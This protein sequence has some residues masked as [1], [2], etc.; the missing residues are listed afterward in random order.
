LSIRGAVRRFFLVTALLSAA[1]PARAQAV[2]GPR[3]DPEARI[4]Y[5]GPDPNTVHI[6]LG[7]NVP[8]GS[9]LRVGAIAAGGAS[10]RAGRSG[11]SARA[12][13]IARFTFD[14]FR[15]RRWGVSA[16]G[17]LSVRYDRI[18]S[19]RGRWRPLLALVVDLEGPRN[20]SVAP[21]LQIGLGGGGRVGVIVRRA[22]ADRR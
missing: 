8:V 17:G 19:E 10:R 11:A 12:D 1:A 22:R 18:A 9:Y 5:L 14:P 3:P 6:G 13:L 16:G 4:D 21:A 20:G 7:M 2:A 15:E